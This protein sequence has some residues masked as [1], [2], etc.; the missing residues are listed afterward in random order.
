MA[1][2][3]GPDIRP[4]CRIRLGDGWYRLRR[5]RLVRIPDEWVG[6]PWD[7]CGSPRLF[8]EYKRKLRR[9]PKK[10]TRRF[11]PWSRFAVSRVPRERIERSSAPRCGEPTMGHPRQRSPRHLRRKGRRMYREDDV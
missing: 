8:R 5:G 1:R 9:A 10:K 6:R 11:D 7:L 2:L 4:G 3:G